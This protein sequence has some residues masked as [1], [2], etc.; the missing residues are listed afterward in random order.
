M[1]DLLWA[2]AKLRQNDAA[3]ASAL[4][5][6]SRVGRGKLP[7]SASA[8]ATPGSPAD[9]PC[10]SNGK[11]AKDGT[12]CTLWSMLLYEYE[13]EL[14]QMGPAPYWN[15]RRLPVVKATGW[16]RA[17]GCRTTPCT[18]NPNSI[19]NG[20]RYIQGLLPATPREMPVPASELAIKSEPFYTFGGKQPPKGTEA[21]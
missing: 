19:Y 10:M 2:E 5:D 8:I 12:P 9:G 16:E 7:S 6:K 20:P 1:N 17:T 15:Q 18:P 4:I 11:L 14:L 21:P 13:I 3:G